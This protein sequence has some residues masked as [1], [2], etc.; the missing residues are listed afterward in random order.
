M[1]RTIKIHGE[2]AEIEFQRYAAMNRVYSFVW[3]LEQNLRGLDKHSDTKPSS[4]GEVRDLFYELR[5][6]ADIPGDL[7]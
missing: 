3:E 2:D 6:E 4:W 5:Q 7:W 1:D